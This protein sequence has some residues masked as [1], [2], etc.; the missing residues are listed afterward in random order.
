MQDQG[1][2]MPKVINFFSPRVLQ[3]MK[4]IE[5]EKDQERLAQL[6]LE[7]NLALNQNDRK[8]R[9]SKKRPRGVGSAEERRRA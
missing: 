3:L 4:Q 9:L 5:T 7:L 6:F 2:D 8:V 1:A